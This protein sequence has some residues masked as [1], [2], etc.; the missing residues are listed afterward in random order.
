MSKNFRRLACGI[1]LT[2]TL[3]G[4]ASITGA[5][6]SEAKVRAPWISPAYKTKSACE[7]ARAR[8]TNFDR[9]AHTKVACR[10]SKY[11]KGWQF[12]VLAR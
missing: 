5:G 10:Y 9:D 2:A 3:A 12:L 11:K 8:F 6:Q 4:G 1:V 7:A